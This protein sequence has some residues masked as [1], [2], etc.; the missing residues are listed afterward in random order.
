MRQ[1]QDFSAA[2]F[3][4]EEGKQKEAAEDRGVFYEEDGGRRGEEK[5]Q[6]EDIAGAGNGV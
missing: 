4:G 6:A 3:L 1:E 5:G 2:D